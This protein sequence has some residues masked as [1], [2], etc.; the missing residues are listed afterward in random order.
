[1]RKHPL[2]FRTCTILL[3][4]TCVC[5]FLAGWALPPPE[6]A[7]NITTKEN[8]NYGSDEIVSGSVARVKDDFAAISLGSDDGLTVGQVVKIYRGKLRLGN[9]IVTKC[10]QN[11]SACKIDNGFSQ[12]PIP[13]DSVQFRLRWTPPNST[14]N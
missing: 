10:N 8:V 2:Q 3:V 5:L 13:G 14:K 4:A 12:I 7:R 1:M 6:F 11:M 9:A